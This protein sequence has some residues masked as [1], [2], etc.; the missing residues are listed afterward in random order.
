MVNLYAHQI[1]GY[2]RLLSY[3]KYCLFFEVG[4]GKTFT[5]LEALMHIP[6]GAKVLIASTKRSIEMMWKLQ[7]A[8]DLSDYD[9]EYLNY[10]KIARDP[11]FALRKYDVLILDEVHRLK[12]KSSKTSTRIEKVAKNAEYVW[13]LTGTPVGNSY[14]DVYEIFKHMDIQEFYCSVSAFIDEYYYTKP[15]R[16]NGYNISLPLNPKPSK[17]NELIYRIGKHSMTV[18]TE[19][20]IDLPDLTV[21]EH[22][23]T[24]MQ[25]KEYK[26]IFSGILRDSYGEQ[27]MTKLAS[28]NK[29]RQAANGFFYDTAGDV[30]IITPNK[31]LDYLNDL[32]DD[33]LNAT[34]QLIVVYYFKQDL[35]DIL[36]LKDY[37]FTQDP[38]KFQNGD[39]QILLLQYGQCE[40]LNLQFVHNIIFYTYDY[41]F[42]NYEQMIGRVKR[43]GQK[44]HILIDVLVNAN[45]IETAVWKAIKNKQSLDEFIKGALAYE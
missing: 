22:F 32:L 42:L 9:V 29:A 31:K 43:I 19:D 39:A 3:K 17:V 2:K 25:T 10:E 28:I 11:K 14:I 37:S 4:L 6:H 41:S 44:Q 23:I 5:A 1:E 40:S 33:R 26:E 34:S 18:R 12:G 36:S 16:L 15:L 13:G 35:Q 45:T 8:Y 27:T 30:E 21:Q 24:G 7:T 20:A 38:I